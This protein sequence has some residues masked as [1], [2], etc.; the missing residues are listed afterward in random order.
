M[1]TNTEIYGQMFVKALLTL[2][3]MET[4]TVYQMMNG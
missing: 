2:W 3:Q 4:P 1:K